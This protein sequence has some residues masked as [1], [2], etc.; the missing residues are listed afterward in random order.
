ML[1]PKAFVDGRATILP[2]RISSSALESP[3]CLRACL[4]ALS[5]T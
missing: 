2:D 3:A 1:Q 5:S 4:F